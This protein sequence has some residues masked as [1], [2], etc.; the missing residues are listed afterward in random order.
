MSLYWKVLEPHL[1]FISS[2]LNK[3]KISKWNFCPTLPYMVQ[4]NY[5]SFTKRKLPMA[6]Q[7]KSSI[8]IQ[9]SQPFKT[10]GPASTPPQRANSIIFKR[11][12][13]QLTTHS[14]CHNFLFGWGPRK[15]TPQGLRSKPSKLKSIIVKLGDSPPRRAHLW[16]NRKDADQL[17]TNNSAFPLKS[18]FQS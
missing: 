9:S 12:R 16:S 15:N 4:T 1:I 5:L 14:T 8:F 6:R 13:K 11:F 3:I 2:L 10:R 17:S 18:I 7:P